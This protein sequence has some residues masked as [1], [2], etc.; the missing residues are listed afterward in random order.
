VPPGVNHSQQQDAT[1]SL[2]SQASYEVKQHENSRLVELHA[3][4]QNLGGCRVWRR[5]Q[6]HLSIMTDEITG[7]D[8]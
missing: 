6:M 1:G 2:Q 4:G 5:M 3:A 7:S 8:Q